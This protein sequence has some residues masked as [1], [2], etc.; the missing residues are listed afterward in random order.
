MFITLCASF[1]NLGQ[2]TTLQT[3]ICG[4]LGWK[5]CSYV[6]LAIQAIIVLFTP[7]LFQWMKDGISHVPPEIEEAEEE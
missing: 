1:A 4:K 5:L 7:K 2:L 3:I 6:G